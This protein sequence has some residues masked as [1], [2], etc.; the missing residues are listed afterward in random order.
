[1]TQQNLGSTQSGQTTN[2]STSGSLIGSDRVEGTSV[3]DPSGKQIGTIKRLIIDK[4]SG[5]VAYA[6][7]QFG[8][9]LGMGGDETPVP[10]HVLDYDRNVGGFRTNI[11]EEQLRGAP[12][13]DRVGSG[14]NPDWNFGDRHREQAFHD[15]YNADYYWNGD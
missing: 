11:T 4:V 10:W 3:H 1:M 2:P 15:Y 13:F 9:F 6:V 7:M 12:S 8:G 14:T 5:R